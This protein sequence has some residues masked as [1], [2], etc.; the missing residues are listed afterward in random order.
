MTLRHYHNVITELWVCWDL[1]IVLPLELFPIFKKFH[2]TY[3]LQP[4]CMN[5][6][7]FTDRSVESCKLCH[8]K[9]LIAKLLLLSIWHMTEKNKEEDYNLLVSKL[10]LLE[11]DLIVV[12]LK[13]NYLYFGYRV[14]L[15][16]F[17]MKLWINKTLMK[18][19]LELLKLAAFEKR[20]LKEDLDDLEETA[21]KLEKKL[22]E[23]SQ[24]YFFLILNIVLQLFFL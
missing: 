14:I 22:R 6:L 3:I 19:E 7:L 2:H 18:W 1:T 17:L 23:L 16:D 20:Q 13:V 4:F 12:R 9:S 21:K 5:L 11:E 15:K 24:Q 8:K 10:K